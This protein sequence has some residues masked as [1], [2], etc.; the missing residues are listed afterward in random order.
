MACVEIKQNTV[1]KLE[2]CIKVCENLGWSCKIDKEDKS[3]CLSYYTPAGEDFN[4]YVNVD[5]FVSDVK[6]Y[7]ED[8]DIEE[9]ATMWIIAKHEGVKGVPSLRVLFDDAEVIDDMLEE[10]SEALDK[11]NNE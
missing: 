5:S 10:L 4:F 7:Y 8:F 11:L 3:I 6:E 1:D 9:H 2:G